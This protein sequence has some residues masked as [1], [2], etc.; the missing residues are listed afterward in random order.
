M[1]NEGRPAV[2]LNLLTFPR[3]GS[4]PICGTGI[5]RQTRFVDRPKQTMPCM[6]CASHRF[7]C[8]P[9]PYRIL[10]ADPGRSLSHLPWC[11]SLTC[12][13]V[14]ETVDGPLPE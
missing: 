1:L 2:W 5:R 13:H 14:T 4:T 6:G 10:T 7:A 9:F 3:R 12:K 11:M 8:G